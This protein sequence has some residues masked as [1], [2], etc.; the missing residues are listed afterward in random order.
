MM[1]CAIDWTWGTI[2]FDLVVP[3]QCSAYRQ[4]AP[5]AGETPPTWRVQLSRGGRSRAAYEEAGLIDDMCRG[6][7]F[8]H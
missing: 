1:Q 7:G 5:V 6:P 3:Q 2:Q 4:W 8:Y